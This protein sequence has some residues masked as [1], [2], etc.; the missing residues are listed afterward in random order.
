MRRGVHPELSLRHANQEL[1][2]RNAVFHRTVRNPLF[3]GEQLQGPNIPALPDAFS[4]LACLYEWIDSWFHPED[5]IKGG[6][7]LAGVRNRHPGS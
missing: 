6:S 4:Y 3:H 7:A 5:L 2:E 1:Y